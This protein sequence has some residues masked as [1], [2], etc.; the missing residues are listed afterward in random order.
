[1]TPSRNTDAAP[2]SVSADDDRSADAEPVATGVAVDTESD[3]GLRPL[4]ARSVLLSALLG[5]NP[6]RLTAAKLVTVADLFGI[7]EG[8]A[9]TALSRMTANGDVSLENGRYRL[10]SR[11]SQRQRRQ[12]LSR[13][14]LR[15]PWSGRWIMA[16]VEP[17]PRSAADRSSLRRSMLEL[18]LGEWR[19]G[20]WLRPDNLG[21]RYS[22]ALQQQCTM[23]TADTAPD[24]NRQAVV[25]RL[26]D[27]DSWA[28]RAQAL[29]A[30]FPE[31][32]GIADRFTVAAAT[33]RHLLSDPLLPDG[34]CP[35][36]WPSSTL[37]QRFTSF[38]ADL[39]TELLSVLR[40]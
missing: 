25:A 17:A 11:L 19:E 3:L 24:T 21:P 36:G 9:R 7:S 12:D 5:T 40:V 16:V 14:E 2:A 10:S 28:A 20:V 34:L 23:W 29:M 35:P 30:V 27:L 8:A 4:T 37:R 1:M 13:G 38:Y 18:R 6:P 26:W 33:L 31:I 15:Q 22:S 39:Q 32:D